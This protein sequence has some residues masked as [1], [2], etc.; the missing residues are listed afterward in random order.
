MESLLSY[1]DFVNSQAAYHDR[2]AQKLSA[3]S[4]N[5]SSLHAEHAEKFRQLALALSRAQERID[6]PPETNSTPSPG[7]PLLSELPDGEAAKAIFANPLSITPDHLIGLPENIVQ[8][9]NITETD[10][11]EANVVN[12]INTAGGT[13]LLDNILIGLYLMTKEV[14]QRQPLSNKLYRM[15]RKEMIFSVPGKKGVYTTK[16]PEG[17]DSNLQSPDLLAFE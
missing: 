16:K 1:L 12:L 17:S 5:K 10:R 14:H 3:T 4:S 8:Q 13:M 7:S 11:F 2:Q 6:N 15:A 9:L